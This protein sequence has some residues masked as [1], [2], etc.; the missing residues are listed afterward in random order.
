MKDFLI[1]KGSMTIICFTFFTVSL[2]S[3]FLKSDAISIVL[4]SISIILF[5]VRIIWRRNELKS[6]QHYLV[7]AEKQANDAKMRSNQLGDCVAILVYL[8]LIILTIPGVGRQFEN[9]NFNIIWIVLVI[10]FAAAI[11]SIRKNS[12][13]LMILTGVL[14][15]IQGIL[16]T[17]ILLGMA[18]AKVFSFIDSSGS[19]DSES[20]FKMFNYDFIIALGYYIESDITIVIGMMICSILLYITFIFIVPAYQLDKLSIAF[21]IVNIVVVLGGI[22]VFFFSANY[23]AGIQEYIRKILES[24]VQ[25]NNF[26]PGVPADFKNYVKGFSKSNLTNMG[27]ILFLPYTF[28]ILI[29]NLL[30]EYLKKIHMIK[31][32]KALDKLINELNNNN[33]TCIDYLE[34]QYYYY[35]GD[36]YIIKLIKNRG[37]LY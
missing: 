34:K 3:A 13:F 19:K 36:K 12:T 22:I 17:F 31:A 11:W 8:Y 1:K 33:E 30:I 28:G 27:Y 14:S 26:I 16:I 5:I 35:G 21:K 29:A 25:Y 23:I 2:L 7:L 18:L 32:K 15:T 24:S 20:I 6:L 9:S 4:L 37:A 10:Y